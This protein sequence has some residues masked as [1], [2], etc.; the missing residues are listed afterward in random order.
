MENC[1]NCE[2]CSYECLDGNY[3]G[4]LICKNKVTGVS[5][6]NENDVCEFY[7]KFEVNKPIQLHKKKTFELSDDLSIDKLAAAGFRSGGWIKK[8]KAPKFF[9]SRNLIGDIEIELEISYKNEVFKFDEY[10]N[11]YVI[12]DNFCQPYLPFYNAKYGFPFLNDVI[13]NNN[14]FMDELVNKEV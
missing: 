13:V 8:V 10:N 12:D 11:I 6:V 3:N 5:C 2:Y 9:I 4:I 7:K 1:G 14:L